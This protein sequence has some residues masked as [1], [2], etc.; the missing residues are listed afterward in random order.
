MNDQTVIGSP[1]NILEC[2]ANASSVSNSDHKDS[3][4]KVCSLS[5]AFSLIEVL[6]YFPNKILFEWKPR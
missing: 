3:D 6:L 4:N 2:I 1:A 5:I